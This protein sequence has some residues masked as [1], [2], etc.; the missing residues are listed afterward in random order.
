MVSSGVVGSQ[1]APYEPSSTISGTTSIE[2]SETDRELGRWSTSSQI[3]GR[4]RAIRSNFDADRGAVGSQARALA[5]SIARSRR[6]APIRDAVT[7]VQ[8]IRET[9]ATERFGR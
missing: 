4:C 2:L 9:D 1:R 5:I 3:S 7:A 8:S 6:I